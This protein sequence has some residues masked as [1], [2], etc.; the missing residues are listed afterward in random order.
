MVTVLAVHDCEWLLYTMVSGDCVQALTGCWPS[1]GFQR[2][3]PHP[4]HRL[5]HRPP[6]L[7]DRRERCGNALFAHP[8]C[9]RI[10]PRPGSVT[11]RSHTARV[12]IGTA[13]HH[14]STFFRP[15][16]ATLRE[17]GARPVPACPSSIIY[18]PTE[19]VHLVRLQA[20]TS[21]PA[22][23]AFPCFF[24]DC[25]CFFTTVLCSATASP[26]PST[27]SPPAF[28]AAALRPQVTHTVLHGGPSP[29]H[30]LAPVIPAGGSVAGCVDVSEAFVRE[31]AAGV[32]PA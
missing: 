14:T 20:P 29:S 3:P 2:R 26:C 17:R 1:E 13:R 11:T 8:S 30:V 24:I 9:D 6:A 18:C 32:F 16:S 23:C 31:L 25:P 22:G 4:R 12:C 19:T 5:L 15:H 21:P 28:T 27:A 7:R 10:L